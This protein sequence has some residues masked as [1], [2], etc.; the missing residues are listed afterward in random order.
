MLENAA[1]ITSPSR[2]VAKYVANACRVERPIEIIPYPIDTNTF[3]PSH[4]A[5]RRMV[6]FVGRVEKRKG[7]DTLMHAIPNVL[8]Q[9]PD[10]EFVF[11]GRLNEE[12][13]ELAATMPPQVKFLGVKP[14]AELV[15]L[16]QQASIVAVPSV[17][18]NSPNV[19]YEAMACGAPVVASN[20]GGIPE[21]V[22]HGVTG[23]LVPPSDAN[24]LTDALIAVLRDAT[25][26]QA[27]MRC[28]REKA[29]ENFALEKILNQT[30]EHYQRVL[31]A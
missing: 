16:Y 29:V 20:V 12:L 10:A 18:D 13:K 24:A 4:T 26:A 17:W 5:K 30:L 25:Q 2:F 8:A 11:V 21:L 19:V 1:A 22:E 3:K 23:L 27:M 7:A 28:A 9:F 6:L 14:R 15:Q 31:D